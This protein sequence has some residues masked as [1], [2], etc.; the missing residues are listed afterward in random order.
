ME[1]QIRKDVTKGFVAGP[2]SRPPFPNSW[3]SSQPK[4][5]TVPKNKLVAFPGLSTS[6][7][8]NTLVIGQPITIQKAFKFDGVNPQTGLYQFIDHSGNITA[9]PDFNQ[10]R[11][12]LINTDPKFYGGLQN[13]IRFHDF[14][15]DFLLQFFLLFI[16]LRNFKFKFWNFLEIS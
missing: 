9:S 1:E 8:A 10:D 5:F 7:L 14:Q 15:L 4:I 12:Q 2:F 6:T 16:S 3:C 11:T 13:T